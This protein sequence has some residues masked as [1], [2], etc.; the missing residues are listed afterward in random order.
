M[1]KKKRKRKKKSNDAILGEESRTKEKREG[2]KIKGKRS[3][4]YFDYN[5]RVKHGRCRKYIKNR[6]RDIMEQWLMNS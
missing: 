6:R 1:K 2:R 4:Y 3:R 5:V